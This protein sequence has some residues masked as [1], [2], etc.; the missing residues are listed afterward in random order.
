M[1]VGLALVVCVLLSLVRPSTV[2]RAVV[3]PKPAASTW[4]DGC[5]WHGRSYERSGPLWTPIEDM[6]TRACP[7]GGLPEDDR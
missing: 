3:L 2:P 5:N 7:E 1:V 4:Y 6:T